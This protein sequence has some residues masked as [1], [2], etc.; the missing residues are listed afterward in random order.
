VP[1][2]VCGQEPPVEGSQAV[3]EL[4]EGQG[5]ALGG[6]QRGTGSL[7]IDSWELSGGTARALGI[8]LALETHP[9]DGT[10]LI[11]EPE[12]SLHPWAIRAVMEHIREVACER[13][14]QV[15]LT[16]H[17]PMVLERVYPEEVRIVER[18]EQKGTI[19]KTIKEILP[20]SDIAMGEVGELWVHGLLG[21]VPSY[22]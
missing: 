7:N 16:T 22:E 15:I 18:S 17:S 1:L 19:F 12:Q 5:I 6:D 11:E 9:E 13:N 4:V 3:P 20:Y 21:G 8:L 2:G 10:L 14:I